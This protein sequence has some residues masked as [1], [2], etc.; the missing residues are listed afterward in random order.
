MAS[1][2][3]YFDSPDQHQ[4]SRGDHRGGKISIFVFYAFL[5]LRLVKNNLQII[6]WVIGS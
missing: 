4:M 3:A 2:A 6:V 5:L 1:A